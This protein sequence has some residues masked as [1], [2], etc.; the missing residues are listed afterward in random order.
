MP[1]IR[2]I[3]QFIDILDTEMGWR[4]KEISAFKI[5]AQSGGINQKVFVRA[6]LTLVYAHWEG[7][8]KTASESY[9]GFVDGQGHTYRDLK[10]CFAV[11]GLKNRLVLLTESRKSAPNIEAF[12]FVYGEMGKIAKM[13]LS[14]AIDT[15]SNLT[16]KVLANIAVSLDIATTPYETKFNLIDESLVRRRNI[17]A[18]GEYLDLKADDFLKLADEIVQVMREYKTDLENAALLK[19]Y[20]RSG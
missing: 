7:F 12:E 3:T 13:S 16:S 15:E 17:I 9:L 18:H 8:I 4:M 5:A 19:A 11:F 14:S 10:S 20:M 2:T 6:G 1:K